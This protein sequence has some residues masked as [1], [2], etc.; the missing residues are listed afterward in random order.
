MIYSPVGNSVLE[1]KSNF[2]FVNVY[3]NV[4]DWKKVSSQAFLSWECQ[5]TCEQVPF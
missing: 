3:K 4:S 5:P 2:I 1:Q